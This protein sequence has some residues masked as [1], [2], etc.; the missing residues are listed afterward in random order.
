MAQSMDGFLPDT[1]CINKPPS[2]F[3]PERALTFPCTNYHKVWHGTHKGKNPLSGWAGKLWL[4]PAVEGWR[5]SHSCRGLCGM[6]ELSWHHKKLPQAA[7]AFSRSPAHTSSH[8]KGLPSLPHLREMPQQ[9]KESIWALWWCTWTTG[10]SNSSSS[11]TKPYSGSFQ[12]IQVKDIFI[13][14]KYLKT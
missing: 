1:G 10:L 8:R 4:N 11:Y 12:P 13:L 3:L 5:C 2:N 7:A 9:R 14:G 6:E